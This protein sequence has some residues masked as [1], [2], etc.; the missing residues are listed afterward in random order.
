MRVVKRL[1]PKGP[2]FDL[3]CIDDHVYLLIVSSSEYYKAP[4]LDRRDVALFSQAAA[5]Y[6]KVRL[7]V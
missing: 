3:L 2:G 4:R 6:Q 7:R 1:L 5:R